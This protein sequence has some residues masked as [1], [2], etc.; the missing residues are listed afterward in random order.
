MAMLAVAPML[1]TQAREL[2]HGDGWVLQP[3]WDGI[4]FLAHVDHSRDVRCW[5]R[6]GTS[7][8]GCLPYLER[9]LAR[10]LPPDTVLDGELVALRAS[11]RGLVVQ[12]FARVR[13]LALRRR[14]HVPN[15]DSPPLELVAFDLPRAAGVDLC[16]EPW[17]RRAQR[18]RELLAGDHPHVT[19]VDDLP[20][21]RD[22]LLRLV[23]LGFEGAVLKLRAGRYRAAVRST[24]WRKLKARH[25]TIATITAT[26]RDPRTGAIDHVVVQDS[27]GRRHPCAVW[28]P[29]LRRR[30]TRDPDAA[31]RHIVTVVYSRIDA[32]GT[33]REARIEPEVVITTAGASPEIASVDPRGSGGPRRTRARAPTPPKS[34]RP[35]T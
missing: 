7:L 30:F 19:V 26:R 1:L 18:L 20:A 3:K 22:A 12:D 31:L 9:E 28:N 32:D 24:N 34:G 14:P 5:T 17:V 27:D 21:T 2:P 16:G 33:L 35:T 29:L 11:D 13:T 4:R 10:Q 15:A 23:A 8:T 25:T 6:R